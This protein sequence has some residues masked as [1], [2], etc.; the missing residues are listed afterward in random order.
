MPGGPQIAVVVD[1]AGPDEQSEDFAGDGSFEKSQNLFF[2]AAVGVLA[3]DVVARLGVGRH[4][5]QR[6]PV[7]RAVWLRGH[8][9]GK[10]GDG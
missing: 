3:L 8:H 4:A 6:N 5:Y 2:G 10:V 9:R 1:G 7:E